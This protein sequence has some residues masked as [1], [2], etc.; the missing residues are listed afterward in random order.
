MFITEMIFSG[1]HYYRQT[2]LNAC[3]DAC[4][5]LPIDAMHTYYNAT[6]MTQGVWFTLA[7]ISVCFK[8]TFSTP[9]EMLAFCGSLV[10]VPPLPGKINAW[11]KE[12]TTPHIVY[13]KLIQILENKSLTA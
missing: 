9:Q 11:D 4:K 1:K 8:V 10:S 5:I 6:E 2:D 3:L 13:G 12:D 7:K